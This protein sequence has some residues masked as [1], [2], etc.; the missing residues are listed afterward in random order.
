MDAE[1]NEN[2][3]ILDTENPVEMGRLIDLGRM[4]TKVMGG[5]LSGVPDLPI[6]ATILDLGCGPGGWVLDT[7]YATPD[8]EVAGVDIS[9]IMVDYSNARA[10]TQGLTNTSFGVMDITESLDFS[11]ATF[12]LV[13]ARLLVGVLKRESWAS[14]I[15]ECKRILKPGGLLRLTEP[16]DGLGV[17]NSVA[18]DKLNQLAYQLF[19][20]AKYGFSTDGHSLGMSTMLPRMLRKAGYRDVHIQGHVFEFSSDTEGYYDI[21]KNLEALAAQAETSVAKLKG[22]GEAQLL[23]QLYEQALRD[24][25]SDEFCGVWHLATMLGTK[26]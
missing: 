11:D 26:E 10:R 2:T 14:F 21:R 5:P 1:T 13:N 8:S 23:K 16:I 3:Y 4:I 17:T 25:R 22:Q 19:W 6:H 24:M 20:N 7:A 12:D 18:F 9:R 15:A